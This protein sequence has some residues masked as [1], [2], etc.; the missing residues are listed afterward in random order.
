MLDL[1]HIQHN[2]TL[3]LDRDGVMNHEIE[4]DYVKNIEEFNMYEESIKAIPLLNQLFNRIIIVTNQKGIGKGLMTEDNLNSIHQLMLQ[5]L[6]NVGGKI[7]QIYFCAD[8]DDLSPN[9]K[10]QP[11]MAFQAK[12][13]FP[14][15]DLSKSIMV[16]NRMSDMN[17]A[18]NAGMYSVFVATTHPETPF[19]D[20]HID[21][22]FPDL[23]HFA[24]ACES[25]QK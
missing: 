8:L 25:A 21:L 16:G 24:L 18:R 3:F 13:H 19:P 11:G 15:I 17:F 12:Q 9:R 5:Q 10:P 7:D 1:H 23:Y 22:R 14:D 6:T 2:W 4:N 20:P